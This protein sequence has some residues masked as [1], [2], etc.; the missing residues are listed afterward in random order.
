[1]SVKDKQPYEAAYA[2]SKLV[3]IKE[4]A[5]YEVALKEFY[6]KHPLLRPVSPDSQ[7]LA[8]KKI[9]KIKREKKPPKLF[10]RVV[11]LDPNDTPYGTTYKYYYVLTYLPD[12]QWCQLVPMT[13]RGKFPDSGRDKFVLIHENECKEL[14]VSAKACKLVRNARAMR[15]TQDADKEEW[16]I[17]DKVVDKKDTSKGFSEERT[18]A[19]ELRSN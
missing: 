14:D 3:H 6:E 12:L 16:D 5:A 19:S 11:Q 1:M 8:E 17:S 15:R 13:T 7:K 9:K 2:K 10:N 4:Q 18:S